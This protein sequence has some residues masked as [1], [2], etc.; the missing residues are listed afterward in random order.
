MTKLYEL[1]FSQVGYADVKEW[2]KAIVEKDIEKSIDDFIASEEGK[3]F[4]YKHSM[5]KMLPNGKYCFCTHDCACYFHR[6]GQRL[7]K[8]FELTEDDLH[9]NE[10]AKR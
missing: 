9:G 4:R 5:H 3:D 10:A 1:K 6:E 2:I 7:M 8:M